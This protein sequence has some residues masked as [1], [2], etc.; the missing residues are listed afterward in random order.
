MILGVA[1]PLVVLRIIGAT[2]LA[3]VTTAI[4]LRLLGMRRGWSKALFSGILG[5]GAAAFIALGLSHWNW[6]ADRLLA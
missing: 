3:F 1:L 6:G 2:A 4:S 5:W